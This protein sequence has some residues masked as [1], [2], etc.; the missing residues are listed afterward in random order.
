MSFSV[1]LQENKGD[2]YEPT[3]REITEYAK[4]IGM[5]VEADATLMWIAREGLKSKLP[6]QWK[7]CRAPTGELYYFN[8]ET[9]DSSWDAPALL[10]GMGRDLPVSQKKMYKKLK[11]LENLRPP[12]A[13][14]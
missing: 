5:D 3:E 14:L 11:V 8:F 6:A 1:I 7:A 9:G 2:N 10:R 13:D 4:W 12:I